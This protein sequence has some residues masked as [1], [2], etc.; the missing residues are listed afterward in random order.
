[1]RDMEE[2]EG[3]MYVAG[4]FLDVVAPDGTTHAQP[5]PR[6]VRP[7]HRG[8]TPSFR[9]VLDGIVYSIEITPDGR[10]YVG[11]EFAGG[12]ALYDARTGARNTTYQPGITLNGAGARPPSSTSKSSAARSISAVGSRA[13]RARRC[14]PRPSRCNHQRYSTRDG[15][16][17]R[18]PMSGIGRGRPARVHALAI[19]STRQRVYV[20]G[21]FGGINGNTDAAYFAI[22]TTT[23]G[24]FVPGL[25]QGLPLGI[26]DHREVASMTM[27]DVHR[28]R[29]CVG[30][31]GS[32]HQTMAARRSRPF[33]RRDLPHQP[34]RRRHRRRGRHPGHH[35][36][37]AHDLVGLSRAGA[38]GRPVRDR[39]L[40]RR[41]HDLR[42]IPAVD[43]RLRDQESVRPATGAWRLRDRQVTT[44]E[45]IPLCE[46][47]SPARPAPTPSWRTRSAGSGSAASLE[48]RLDRPSRERHDPAVT[49]GAAGRAR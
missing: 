23:D 40:R 34:G 29:P 3:R 48:R 32:A 49:H 2:F 4:K 43:L 42:R 38:D 45:L 30:S 5:S 36:R 1:M 21:K 9:P 8:G 10:L 20:A 31:G 15:R 39:Q 47:T 41:A 44:E 24:S 16:R 35:H 13:P 7:R 17:W 12:S 37:Q 11:G 18:T 46:S 33:G 19:D 28:G 6:S 25:P 27:E 14:R 22:L 26:P